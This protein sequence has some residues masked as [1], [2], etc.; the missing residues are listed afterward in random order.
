ML[1]RSRKTNI[2]H[3]GVL[4]RIA[5]IF[6][7]LLSAG[8]GDRGGGYIVES[9]PHS[10]GGDLPTDTTPP[11]V[12]STNPGTN[13]TAIPINAAISVSFSEVVSPASVTNAT[14]LVKD[15]S[16]NI[17]SGT[18]NCNGS[19]A[20]FTP[21]NWLAVSTQ[22]TAILTT[23][24][25]D[26]GGNHLASP[27]QW[28]FTTSAQ[29]DPTPP[30]ITAMS[31]A[32]GQTGIALS[33]SITVTFSE[34]VDPAT[35]T[36]STVTLSDTWNVQVGAILSVSGSTLVITP[37][38]S[39]TFRM[40]YAVCITT[41]VA[42]LAGNL[43]S[44]NQCWSFS[45]VDNSGFFEPYTAIPTGSYPEAVAIGD[46]TGDGKNDVVL[47]TSFYFDPT[48][49]Y[50]VFLFAQNVQGG[51]ATAVTCTTSGTY[52]GRPMSVAVGDVNNDGKNEI[53]VGNDRSKIEVFALDISGNLVS[54][55]TYTTVNSTNIRIADLNHDGLL[56]IVGIGWGTNTVGVFLQNANG[57]LDPPITYAVSHEG[58]DDL[59]VGDI[60]ND[61]LSDI[62]V[63]S[64]QGFSPNIGVLIQK[65]DGTFE[66]AVYYDLGGNELAGGVAVGD[67]NGDNLKD[68]VIS[69]GWAGL[70]NGLAVFSQN[71][72][73]TLNAPTP[74]SF[75]G[76]ATAVEIADVN[77][78]GRQDVIIRQGS[79]GICLQTA[80]GTLTECEFYDIPSASDNRHGMAIGDINNDGKPD[81]VIA[82]VWKG[83][84]VLYHQ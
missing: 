8:C 20:T 76:G 45:T 47:V 29:A 15:P 24:I 68:I 11:V 57:T 5:C 40:T 43:L 10:P 56:D 53:V 9:S 34:P 59:E 2:P 37:D 58:W 67:V 36:A 75:G 50:H 46:V 69:T 38:S 79:A 18:L 60:N 49:D 39:L 80:N 63:M 62:I 74:Y 71:A 72:A 4:L 14:F 26:I 12:L 42:D 61:G 3:L 19:F 77:S 81:I 13:D 1:M 30:T 17:V 83:L 35:I 73:G 55:A 23:G 52:S 84:V 41:G 7:V 16:N 65:S 25:T 31:P 22:Y 32:G 28:T 44:S 21:S 6:A 33:T 78:D 54:I 64:G 27:F 48:H 82:D 66:P 51:L 70:P